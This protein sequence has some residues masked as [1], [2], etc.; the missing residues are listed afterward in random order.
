MNFH[1][2]EGSEAQ[3]E[4]CRKSQNKSRI[5]AKGNSD[6]EGKRICPPEKEGE[7]TWEG[8]ED[9][10]VPLQSRSTWYPSFGR[11]GE[12]RCKNG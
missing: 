11:K 12:N 3:T 4:E 8:N 2:G 7:E 5:E 1:L 10:E 6:V 9:N